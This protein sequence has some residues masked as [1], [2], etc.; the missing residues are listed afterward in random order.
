MPAQDEKWSIYVGFD[1]REAAAFA[2][3]RSS[4][5]RHMTRPVPIYGLV[6]DELRE[7][8]LYRR[9]TERRGQ[10]LWDSISAAP[11]STEFAISR[12]LTPILAKTGLA[13]FTDGDVLVRRNVRD[14]FLNA[15]R[16]KAVL[17]V[18]HVHAPSTSVKMDG[19]IQTAY[20]RK[21]WSSVVLFNCDHPANARLTVELVNSAPGRDLHR[22]CWLNDDEIGDL[23]VEWNWLVGHSQPIGSPAIVHFTDGFPLMSGYE[24]QPYAQEWREALAAW[25]ASPC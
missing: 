12:F 15:D 21:N 11:M 7:R 9:P 3:A 23:K 17:C 25:A 22:F 4:F 6:L 8:G 24:E 18:K 20:P 13:L 2:V 10:Q 1:T 16:S 5:R 14:L 19:Q